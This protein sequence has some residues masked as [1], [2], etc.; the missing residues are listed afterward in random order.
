MQQM[1]HGAADANTTHKR[2]NKYACGANPICVSRTH[3][4]VLSSNNMNIKQVAAGLR[5]RIELLSINVSIGVA[6]STRLPF[7]V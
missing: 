6:L 3:L 1:L 4:S 5:F 2:L 7:G